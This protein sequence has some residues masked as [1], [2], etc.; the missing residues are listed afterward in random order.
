M[1]TLPY[2]LSIHCDN[3]KIYKK[4]HLNYSKQ[5]TMLS[6]IYY[7]NNLKTLSMLCPEFLWA[8]C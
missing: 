1:S 2:N 4:T 7:N 8:Y 3:R 6:E 5:K